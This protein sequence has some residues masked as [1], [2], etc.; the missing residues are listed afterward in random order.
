MGPV[1]RCFDQGLTG[2]SL[3]SV[4][5]QGAGTAHGQPAGGTEGKGLI[6]S[7]LDPEEGV[8]NRHLIFI[9]QVDLKLLFMGF[10]IFVRIETK[11]LKRVNHCSPVSEL[12]QIQSM[13][14]VLI[15]PNQY[16]TILSLSS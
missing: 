12:I 6:L 4:H 14:Q 15:E 3:P 16:L 1:P 5:H 7:L 11:N 2:Q 13:S 8:Q 9:A 10:G